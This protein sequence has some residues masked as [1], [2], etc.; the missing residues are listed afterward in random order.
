MKK[1]EFKAITGPGHTVTII[2][3]ADMVCMIVPATVEGEVVG[4]DKKP[5]PKLVAGLDFGV[6]VIPVDC[7]IQEATEK[8]FGEDGYTKPRVD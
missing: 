7:S 3:N 4:P 8:I 6:R 2:V 5:I 1:V